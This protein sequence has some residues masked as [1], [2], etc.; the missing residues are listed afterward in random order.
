[1][2]RE[3]FLA[4]QRIDLGHKHRLAVAAIGKATEQAGCAGL[5][6]IPVLLDGWALE[7]IEI[8]LFA[9]L[10]AIYN[11]PINTPDHVRILVKTAKNV[12]KLISAMKMVPLM[13]LWTS[14]V[15]CLFAS[16]EMT[17]FGATVSVAFAKAQKRLAERDAMQPA[18]LGFNEVSEILH[19]TAKEV[20]R[21]K[22]ASD[23]SDEGQLLR[24]IEELSEGGKET[25]GAGTKEMC[26]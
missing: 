12:F 19:N 10:V 14:P 3:S 23:L 2:G 17:R 8:D 9:R 26:D 20:L 7:R 15:G 11:L 5:M 21:M 22:L 6:P 25:T 4:A 16:S 1:L 18:E 13:A 24:V